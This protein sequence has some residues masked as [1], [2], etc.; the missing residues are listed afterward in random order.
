VTQLLKPAD[1]AK[2]LALSVQRI[3]QLAQEGKIASVKLGNSVRFDPGDVMEY[4]RS[5]RRE[6]R[7]SHGKDP[8]AR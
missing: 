4:I 5:Q 8:Q 2:A 3:Y 7:E 1:V 6:R